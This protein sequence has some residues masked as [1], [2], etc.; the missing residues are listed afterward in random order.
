MVRTGIV[1]IRIG[2]TVDVGESNN[3]ILSSIKCAEILTREGTLEVK[4]HFCFMGAVS[5]GV[6]R[7]SGNQLI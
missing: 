3:E 5:Q 6:I 4:E 2:K 7:L 1:C